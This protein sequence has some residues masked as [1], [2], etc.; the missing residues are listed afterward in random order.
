MAIDQ[1]KSLFSHLPNRCPVVVVGAGP[2]GLIASLLLSKY[3]VR[4]L[5]V[6]QQ[7][8]PDDHPQAHFINHRS[9]EVFRELDRLDR[10]VLAESAPMNEWR[11]FVYCTSLYNLPDAKGAEVGATGSMLGVVDHLSNGGFETLSPC[12]VTHFPQHD[13]VRLLRRRAGS[14]RF[15]HLLE[16]CRT[17]VI[18]TSRQT[19]LMLTDVRTNRRHVQS[20]L[21]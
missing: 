21:F 20:T 8:Q 5:L 16:G 10:T 3:R 17:D 18:E 12:P 1:S 7:D 2:V 11:R 14:S 6:D 15:C 4:H 19:S 9:M 13:F